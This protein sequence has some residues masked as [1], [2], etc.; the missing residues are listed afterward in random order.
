M[1]TD[2]QRKIVD[3]D[4]TFYKCFC[5]PKTFTS[6]DR[7][8]LLAH[9][10]EHSLE[11][12]FC[13]DCNSLFESLEELE[14][15]RAKVHLDFSVLIN[16]LDPLKV[17]EIQEAEQLKANPP[18]MATRPTV[19]NTSAVMARE[20]EMNGDSQEHYQQQPLLIQNEDGS[21]LNN[22]LIN[23]NGE[24]IVQNYDSLL[25]NGHE[26]GESSQLQQIEQFLLEQGITDTSGI[27]YIQTE[28]GQILLQTD[29]SHIDQE[30][31]MQMLQQSQDDVS[32]HQN[33]EVEVEVDVP[34]VT[35]NPENQAALDELGDI[36]LEVAAAA[37]NDKSSKSS[38]SRMIPSIKRKRENAQ[39]G[40]MF[41]EEPQQKRNVRMEEEEN[42]PVK[43][44]SQAYEYFVKGF[45]AM[46]NKI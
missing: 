25:Q 33:S 34:S 31:L 28:D 12:S 36:L 24:L 9:I 2:H 15:H 11:T 29:D 32:E 40:K 10:K 26:L 19:P 43:N 4:D 22:L 27:S 8:N 5:C 17:F 14:T 1:S 18:S 20:H 6:C 46:R 41:K 35:I 42:Q 16:K 30:A 13:T 45:D 23:E 37:D 7:S 3:N 21:I 44:F 38:S 39:N